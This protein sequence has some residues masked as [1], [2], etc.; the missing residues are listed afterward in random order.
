MVITKKI[1]TVFGK[2]RKVFLRDGSH[3]DSEV[4]S[5]IFL[6]NQYDTSI[7]PQDAYLWLAYHDIIAK[8]RQPI[9]I[10]CGAFNG[11]SALYYATKYPAAI[12]I[13]IEPEEENYT[14][15]KRNTEEMKN[16]ITVHSAIDSENRPY[17]VVDL[18]YG[19]WGYRTEQVNPGEENSNHS[20]T[21]HDL[22]SICGGELED[23]FIVKIDIEGS[24]YTLFQGNTD[25]VTSADLV[26]AELH[27]RLF[28]GQR[29]SVPFLRTIARLNRD[30]LYAG[31]NVF[32]F[33][34]RD[35]HRR[36]DDH[37]HEDRGDVCS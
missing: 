7:F 4:F 23:L 8:K 22:V 3:A 25:W 13:A 5:Q 19:E 17:S 10:D 32:S 28:P 24:E 21:I 27:D 34:C 31:E 30:F 20:K 18:G 2:D 37:G 16:I 12:I 33:K 9:I 26:V 14:L 36:S 35:D 29:R 15:L 6:Q 11:F 1:V